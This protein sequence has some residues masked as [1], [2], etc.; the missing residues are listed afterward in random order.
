MNIMQKIICCLL[1]T[2]FI[3][4]STATAQ[5]TAARKFT[6]IE[7]EVE[8]YYRQKGKVPGYKQFK[9]WQWYYETRVAPD[10]SFVNNSQYKQDALEQ[11]NYLQPNSPEANTGAWSLVGPTSVSEGG[12]SG[13]GRCNRI[14]FHPTNANIFFIC[15]AGGGLWKTTNAGSS[16]TCLTNGLPNIN[17]CGMAI[18]YTNTN[19][20]YLLTGDGDQGGPGGTISLSRYSI[21]LLKSY[22][23][24][25]TWY[26][27]GLTFPETDGYVGYKVVMHPTNPNIL[28][29]ATNNGLWR[30]ANAGNSWTQLSSSEEFYD[31]EFKP[32][33]P[34]VVF[35]CTS[36]SF[37]KSTN[38]GQSFSVTGGVIGSTGFGRTALAVC[39]SNFNKVFILAGKVIANDHFRGFYRYD[40]VAETITLVNDAPNI[41]GRDGSGIDSADQ[42]GY[43]LAVVA[44]P[45]NSNYVITGGIREWRTT[46]GGTSFTFI[47]NVDNYHDDIH[48]LA[49]NPLN[50]Q[51]Y[52]CCDGGVYLSLDNG[53]T[54]TPLNSSLSISQYYKIATIASNSSLVM[55]SLQDNGTNKRILNGGNFDKILGADGLDCGFGNTSSIIYAGTQDGKYYQSTNGGST[56]PS[57][58]F[59]SET[60]VQTAFGSS[61][62]ANFFTPL[63]VHPTNDNIVYLGYSKLIKATRVLGNTYS[64]TNLVVP[65][66]CFVKVGISNTNRIYAGRNT[67]HRSSTNVINRSDDGGTTF[68]Q[69]LNEAGNSST[70]AITDLAINPGN[71]L[72]IWYTYGGYSSTKKVYYSSDGGAT[73]TNITGSLPNVPINCVIYGDDINNAVDPVYIGT[74]I[75]I[76]YRDNNLGDWIPFSNGLPVVEVTELEVNASANILWAGTYGRGIWQSSLY[77]S[78]AATLN[79]TTANQNFNTSY[80]H[81]VSNNI[82]STAQTYSSGAQVFYKAGVEIVLQDGFIA[83]AVDTTNGFKAFISAC[84]GGVPVYSP[85][86][87]AVSRGKSGFLAGKLR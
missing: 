1:L 9:R 78:C 7:Q 17:T 48:D 72:E 57:S 16:Y 49:Y 68:T 5:I 40:D 82:T 45:D 25:Q 60:S 69:V 2:F 50:N 4:S 27:T 80:Y 66:T 34:S 84:G 47:S 71:S 29:V 51:L 31:I 15:T 85:E 37:Y 13:I 83:S 86:G 58:S 76:F 19:I 53:I 35:A 55:G 43:D 87:T 6:D 11:T 64:L 32:G 75:G 14:T 23:G 44:K 81:Q 46:N 52:M 21:G 74:D 26:P 67:T 54:W 77:S 70:P 20:L 10:G 62:T 30:T 39:P 79:L 28:I 22:D 8:N 12:I 42:S 41:L 18:D 59:C 65:A 63:A 36:L 61:I 73:F 56:F 24:G 33:S 38:D 3:H